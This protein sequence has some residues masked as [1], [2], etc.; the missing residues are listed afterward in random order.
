MQKGQV[1]GAFYRNDIGKIDLVW[2]KTGKNG[3]GLAHILEGHSEITGNRLRN[4]IEKGKITG[5]SK[6]RIHLE[7]GS[8]ISSIRLDWDGKEKQWVLT[9]FDKKRSLPLA[10]ST[11][12]NEIL[13]SPVTLGNEQTSKDKISKP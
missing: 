8:G 9:A 13:K 10:E 12:T 2:G 3:Y 11:D 1:T 5:R 4:I 6:N 7:Y